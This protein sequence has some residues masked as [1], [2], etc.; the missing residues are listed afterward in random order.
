ML[1]EFYFVSL[2]TVV[3]LICHLIWASRIDTVFGEELESVE[4]TQ[5]PPFDPERNNFTLAGL[6]KKEWEGPY[7]AE[8][9]LGSTIFLPCT[10]RPEKMDRLYRMR[11]LAATEKYYWSILW[12]HKTWDT[13][14]DPWMGDGRRGYDRMQLI[15]YWKPDLTL[16]LDNA[17]LSIVDANPSDN[18][19]YAC[20]VAMYPP[21]KGLS[22]VILS[23]SELVSVHFLRIKSGQVLPSECTQEE[24]QDAMHCLT[25]FEDWTEY[26]YYPTGIN[27]GDVI[28]QGECFE[29][30]SG[31]SL[32]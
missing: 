12:V 31:K 14:I 16:S 3:I 10:A 2:R 24:F 32:V 4:P 13:V 20:V 19:V 8:A 27:K 21:E 7:Y 18:G 23:Q 22:P 17:R 28:F 9:F 25:G 1:H 11:K 30:L 26:V 6:T 15:P 5:A 29:L